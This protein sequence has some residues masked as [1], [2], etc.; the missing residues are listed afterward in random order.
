MSQGVLFTSGTAIVVAVCLQAASDDRLRA[1]Q[2][3]RE[4]RTADAM[5]MFERIVERDPRDDEARVWLA[6]LALRLGRTA[7]AA[8]GF[9]AV[10]ARRP[11][12][13][14][15]SI[16]LGMTL[17]RTNDWRG[18]L[19]LLEPLEAAA[20]EN[21]G[22]LATTALAYRRAGDDRRAMQYFERARA[23][24]PH[25]PDIV[26]G[27]E[28]VA[29][30]YGHAIGFDG[31][32]QDGSPG[33]EARSGALSA[34]LRVTPAL[35]LH[36]RARAQHRPDASDAIGGGG[37]L[38]RAGLATT[39]SVHAFGGPDNAA[40]PQRNFSAD[41]LHYAGA[42]EVGGGVH[43]LTFESSDVFVVTPTFAWDRDRWRLD[44]RYSL[45]HTTFLASNDSSRDHSVF[46]RGTLRPWQRVALN[47][48]YAH[49]IE[50]FEDITADEL[51]SLGT[52]TAAGG[53]QFDLPSLSRLSVTWE[54]Q[55]R[56]NDTSINRLSVSL[57]QIL[58]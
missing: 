8:A 37:I 34:D 32:T 33:L 39:I 3:A 7:D 54:H 40:L 13:V 17:L 38:W 4:G 41:V 31:F 12:D 27:Y 20:P 9:R 36:L 29:R 48:V 21:A 42:F 51:D 15:A 10:L 22:L 11:G 43:A 14:D 53:A 49:G 47:A 58:R 57:V 50:S 45:S 6:R 30:V 24:A 23:R 18:A 2:L 26:A 44:T 56:S 52:T 28:A 25:D 55:W 19:A 16:G 46:V 5:A 1:E 35:R